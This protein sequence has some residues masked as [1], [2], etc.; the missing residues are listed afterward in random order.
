MSYPIFKNPTHS[1]PPMSS[2]RGVPSSNE[3][4]LNN[5]GPNS[6]GIYN[7]PVVNHLHNQ[8]SQASPIVQN[9]TLVGKALQTVS[10]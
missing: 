9:D 5:Q 10:Q 2:F 1:L 6:P 8:H 3:V 4:S 7:S